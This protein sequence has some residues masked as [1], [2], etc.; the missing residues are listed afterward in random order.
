MAL[1]TNLLRAATRPVSDW[2]SLIFY[3]GFISN[4][5]WILLEL[6]SIPLCETI[7]PRN[8][9]DDTPKAHLLGFNFMLYCRMYQMFPVG[10]PDEFPRPDF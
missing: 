1:E 5:A 9:P 6:A 3:G 8:F 10:C 2:T 4:I 7:K